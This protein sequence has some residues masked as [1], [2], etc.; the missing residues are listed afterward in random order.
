MVGGEIKWT[1]KLLGVEDYGGVSVNF[2]RALFDGSAS[3]DHLAVRYEELG[4]GIVDAHLLCLLKYHV[5]DV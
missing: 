1:W 5:I 3:V 4:R 2:L